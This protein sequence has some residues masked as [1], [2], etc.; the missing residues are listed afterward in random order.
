MRLLILSLICLLYPDTS[1]T[2]S[3]LTVGK[4]KLSRKIAETGPN[5]CFV[6]SV[7]LFEDDTFELVFKTIIANE[8]R[9]YVY[10]GEVKDDGKANINLGD[11]IAQLKGFDKV[12][13]RVDFR[14][15]YGD[16]LGMFCKREEHPYPHKHLPHDLLGEKIQE[17]K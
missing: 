2:T 1:T 13:N 15:E 6:D 7:S 4:W 5:R 12:K 9:V 14:F 17:S 10:T 3:T 8:Q 16:K 11:G